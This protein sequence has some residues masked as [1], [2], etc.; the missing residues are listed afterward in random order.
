MI[1]YERKKKG[2]PFWMENREA[3]VT[4]NWIQDGGIKPGWFGSGDDGSFIYEWRLIEVLL[5]YSYQDQLS[6]GSCWFRVRGYSRCG[7]PSYNLGPGTRVWR[8]DNLIFLIWT[9]D[10]ENMAKS[11]LL[12]RNKFFVHVFVSMLW[13]Q[14]KSIT[15][16]QFTKHSCFSFL[17]LSYFSILWTKIQFQGLLL[18]A[19]STA[20]KP[21]HS[22]GPVSLGP[23][24]LGPVLLGQTL[25]WSSYQEKKGKPIRS[26]CAISKL[27]NSVFVKSLKVYF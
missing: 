15:S 3:Q 22:L 2:G 25:N 18:F 8:I 4:R 12:V 23:V 1:I 19:T 17:T 20:H 27:Q 26:I 6:S 21:H 10:W 5:L 24:S 13:Y 9:V 11:C 14:W 16:D 7:P